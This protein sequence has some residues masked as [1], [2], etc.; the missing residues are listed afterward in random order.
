MV[1]RRKALIAL[2]MFAGAVHGQ[3]LNK[4][5]ARRIGLL[6][7]GDAKD[8]QSLEQELGAALTALGWKPGT[9]SFEGVHADDK[10]ERLPALAEDLVALGHHPGVEQDTR[11][12]ALGDPGLTGRKQSVCG[13]DVVKL[14]GMGQMAEIDRIEQRRGHKEAQRG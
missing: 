10:L 5:Q 14:V 2:P 9:V 4:R 7:A 6:F 8:R 11:I 3:P 12:E 1:S 13:D